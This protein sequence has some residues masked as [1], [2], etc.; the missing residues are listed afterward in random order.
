MDSHS[1]S[2]S[3]ILLFTQKVSRWFIVVITAVSASLAPVFFLIVRNPIAGYGAVLSLLI[4]LV[5]LFLVNQGNIRLGNTLYL[6]TLFLTILTVGYLN[7]PNSSIYPAVLIS[8]VGLLMGVLTPAGILVSPLYQ[9]ILVFSSIGSLVWFITQS[10]V[11]TLIERRSLLVVVILFQGAVSAAIS[12]VARK[13]M[14]ELQEEIK[15][16]QNTASNLQ[17]I[18]SRLGTI[19]VSTR[20]GWEESRQYLEKI[21]TIAKTYGQQTET[22]H[23]RTVNLGEYL[24]QAQQL[25]HHLY[26]VISKVDSNLQSQ[27]ERIQR[28]VEGQEEL[29]KV[30]KEETRQMEEAEKVIQGLS[31]ASKQGSNDLTA[32]VQAIQQLSE[33]QKE[34]L[35][36]NGMINH[37][38]AQTNL[39]AMNATI[40][41]AH[42]GASGRGF[43]VVAEEVRKLSEEAKMRST[44]TRS[45]I[46][47]MEE[48]LQVSLENGKKAGSSLKEIGRVSLEVTSILDRIRLRT[49]SF[50][51]IGARIQEDMHTL[52]S[53]HHHVLEHLGKEHAAFREYEESFQKLSQYLENMTS[54][55]R[56]LEAHNQSAQKAM[57]DLDQVRQKIEQAEQEVVRL[58]E[59]TLK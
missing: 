55:I 2:S 50:H 3:S 46:R 11:P 58:L 10:G 16:S 52:D 28:S 42:A 1:P 38:A 35:A 36:I 19:Q 23:N 9:G 8:V 7:I 12:L 13:L 41:A 6:S 33:F 40:E 29:Q 30:L 48:S 39:L 47:K 49:E 22:L 45:L 56:D 5:S 59:M 18:L 4:A 26:T 31:F 17:Q 24:K 20:K 37:I 57:Q 14:E 53:F 25:F 51:Q 43:A 44:E 27:G 21:D 15:K 54:I 32:V 34:L